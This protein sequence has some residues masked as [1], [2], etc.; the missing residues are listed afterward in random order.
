MTGTS[1]IEGEDELWVRAMRSL[2]RRRAGARGWFV[3]PMSKLLKT[4]V[5][6]LDLD[7]PASAAV[8]VERVHGVLG[9]MPHAFD[10]PPRSDAGQ[11][12]VRGVVEGDMPVVVTVDIGDALAGGTTLRIRAFAKELTVRQRRAESTARAVAELL[13]RLGEADRGAETYGWFEVDPGDAAGMSDREL[14]FFSAL[15]THISGWTPDVDGYVVSRAADGPTEP[16]IACLDLTDPGDQRRFLFRAGVHLLG[17]RVRGDRLHSQVFSLPE[18][19]S[20]WAL[21]ASGT[22]ERLGELSASWF[23]GVL[24]KPVVLYV[25]LRNDYAYAA[26]YAF[27]D[28]GETLT[29]YY[30]RRLA[31]AGQAEELIAAGHVHGRG[32]IQTAGLPAPTCYLHIRGDLAKGTVPFGVPGTTKRGPLRGLWYEGQ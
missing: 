13:T 16:L 4:V 21:D 29:Q 6:E 20:S 25:W 26:R 10:V 19:P 7:L 2:L 8:T 22:D 3:R 14:A 32:W 12:R 9:S 18:R 30:E 11:R 17:D 1:V 28:T 15:R 23:R 31:P 24:D 5:H 27:A